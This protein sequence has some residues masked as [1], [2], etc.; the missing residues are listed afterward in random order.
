MEPAIVAANMRPVSIP[1]P[2]YV[3]R[4]MSVDYLSVERIAVP[5]VPVW[6]LNVDQYH[7]MIRSGIL[8]ELNGCMLYP[9]FEGP[10]WI[11]TGD[12]DHA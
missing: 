5:T 10:D 1:E 12:Y 3:S 8:T 6:R 4:R 2:P 9:L 7:R 11:Y